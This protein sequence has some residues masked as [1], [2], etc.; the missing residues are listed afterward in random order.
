MGLRVCMLQGI[1]RRSHS[2]LLPAAWFDADIVPR[3]TV[4]QIFA[5]VIMACG[6]LFFAFL[7]GGLLTL[8]QLCLL[9]PHPSLNTLVARCSNVCTTLQNV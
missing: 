6:A 2:V 8:L 7:V 4:E 1:P 5:M 9:I 3:S